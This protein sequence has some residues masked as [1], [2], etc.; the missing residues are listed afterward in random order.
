MFRRAVEEGLLDPK[1]TVQIGIRGS[2]Y[3]LH[4]LDF[5]RDSG[6]RVIGIEEYFRLGWE[7]VVAEARAVVGEGPTYISFDVD[8]LDP[9][10][11]PGTGT[12]EI[13]GFSTFEAQCML[14]GAR[15]LNLVGGDVVEVAPPFDPSGNTALVGAT[16]MFEI[17]VRARR[18]GGARQTLTREAGMD[19]EGYMRRAIALCEEKMAAGEGGYCA[20]LIVRDGE[21]IGEGWNNVAETHDATG[22]CEINA[23]RD[24]GRRTGNWDLS[25]SVLYTTWEP[26]V[27]CAA[28][29]WW[30]RIERVFYGNLLSPGRRSRHRHR[31]ARARG[32]D[33]D[34]AARPPLS[35]PARRRDLRHVQG[36]VGQRRAQHALILRPFGVP[37]PQPRLR[38]RSGR[39]IYEAS[40]TTKGGD[41]VSDIRKPRSA[42][43][44]NWGLS[45]GWG[46]AP[47][48]A[49][50][51]RRSRIDK[52]GSSQAGG[53]SNVWAGR[54]HGA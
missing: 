40:A 25:G 8:G 54:R 22:H 27:M 3:D 32:L 19:H 15:G 34:R 9:V 44:V 14:R 7:K 16:M 36:L 50:A 33:P 41:P 17:P 42:V 24:A 1:R 35:A 26:C 46:P 10:Y 49:D 53:P 13:G 37:F 11:A 21:V 23:I 52:E 39:A 45:L 28:A 6:M 29:I 4:D 12:P 51:I 30:A 43:A 2:V 48:S 20:T 5:A 47:D 31:R 18:I 38:R